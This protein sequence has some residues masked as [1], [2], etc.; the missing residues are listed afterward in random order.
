[1]NE[2][3]TPAMETG[4]LTAE[5][6]FSLLFSKNNPPVSSQT[7]NRVSAVIAPISSGSHKSPTFLPYSPPSPQSQQAFPGNPQATPARETGSLTGFSTSPF[8]IPNPIPKSYSHL[9]KKITCCIH[10]QHMRQIFSSS[11]LPHS[12]CY[13]SLLR[14]AGILWKSSK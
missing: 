1:M 2:Q 3:N 9:C 11:L 10:L 6:H 5:L 7:S 14:P 12:S 13:A 4:R 8:S